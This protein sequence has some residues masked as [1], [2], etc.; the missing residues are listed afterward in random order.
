MV[1]R[2]RIIIIV[3]LLNLPQPPALK[4][5]VIWC[6]CGVLCHSVCH[7]HAASYWNRLDTRTLDNESEKHEEEE[8]LFR[9]SKIHIVHLLSRFLFTVYVLFYGDMNQREVFAV[10]RKMCT[11]YTWTIWWFLASFQQKWIKL[12]AACVWC[13]QHK[14]FKGQNEG[15][16]Q[17]LSKIRLWPHF[18]VSRLM[19][20]W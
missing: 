6:L 3:G 20:Y 19:L 17:T 13:F 2:K 10:I 9:E 5:R 11:S 7:T 1:H 4:H 16:M 18:G 14:H 12:I 8:L 15:C